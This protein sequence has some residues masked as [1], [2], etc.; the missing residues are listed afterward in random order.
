MGRERGTFMDAQDRVWHPSCTIPV[1]M[2]AARELN[3]TLR[4]IFD[5][6]IR[7]DQCID[8]VWYCCKKEA[9]ERQMSRTDFFDA[10]DFKSLTIAI[11]ATF[12][13]IIASFPAAEEHLRRVAEQAGVP[14]DGGQ[15]ETS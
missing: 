12:E 9:K 10:L 7:L 3:I 13:G 5:Q 8:L 1:I 4:N 15:S 14:L 6:S 11:G 2:E